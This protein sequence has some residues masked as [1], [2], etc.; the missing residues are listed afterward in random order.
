MCIRDS[1]YIAGEKP[2]FAFVY[3]GCTDEVGHA[4]GWMSDEYYHACSQSLDEVGR[5]VE[6]FG[7]PARG[8]APKSKYM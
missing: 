7:K 1:S 6:C 4:H 3:L 5:L 2:D 8:R